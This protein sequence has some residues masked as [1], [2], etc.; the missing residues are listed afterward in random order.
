MDCIEKCNQIELKSDK[1]NLIRYEK[2]PDDITADKY[3]DNIV[4]RLSNLNNADP[5][6]KKILQP[7]KNHYKDEN[8]Q[9]LEEQL[10]EKKKKTWR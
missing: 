5:L 10:N 9:Q 4:K 8:K 3:Y 7:L 1:E 2:H 6:M